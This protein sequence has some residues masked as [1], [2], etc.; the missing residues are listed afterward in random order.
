MMVK[1]GC[2]S[3]LSMIQIGDSSAVKAADLKRGDKVVSFNQT[4]NVLEEDEVI[5]I[6]KTILSSYL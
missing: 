1:L 5:S 3:P 6:H 2:F 4:T